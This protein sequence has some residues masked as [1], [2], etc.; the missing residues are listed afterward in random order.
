MFGGSSGIGEAVARRVMARGSPV[1]I[2]RRDPARLPA[3]SSRLGGDVRTAVA[4]A[5]DR[6]A[7]DAVFATEVPAVE[8]VLSLSTRRV[9]GPFRD[10]RMEDLTAVVTGKL[11]AYLSVLQRRFSG[12]APMDGHFHRREK[13]CPPP[14]GHGRKRLAGRG[15]TPAGRRAGAASVNVVARSDPRPV[16]ACDAQAGA[17]RSIRPARLGP[18]GPDW[19][20]RPCRRHCRAAD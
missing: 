19:H 13:R 5:V 14:P 12:C 8:L 16:V 6:D 10:V 7:V 17:R 20:A 18:G 2:A 4:D 11:V 9:G 1:V 3:A 15:Y